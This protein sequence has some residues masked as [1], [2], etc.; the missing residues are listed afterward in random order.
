ML[1]AGTQGH[2]KALRR[3]YT[4]PTL[5]AAKDAIDALEL[6]WGDRYPGIVQ[7]WRPAQEQYTL[8]R[9]NCSGP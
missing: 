3:I 5:E 7:T 6:E 4:A 2:I 1:V 9:R 8:L